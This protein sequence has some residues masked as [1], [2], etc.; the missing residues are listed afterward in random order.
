VRILVIA[1]EQLPVPAIIGGSVETCIDQVFRRLA[2]RGHRV[3]VISR[4]HSRLPQTEI[5]SG[6]RIR[7]IRISANN[8]ESYIRRAVRAIHAQIYDV[9]QVE[10]R[11][12]FIQSVRKQFP[13]TPLVLSLHSLTFMSRLSRNRG[14][15]ILRL[16]N[17]TMTVSRSITSTMKRR[18]PAYKH[19]FFTNHQGVDTRQFHP[20]NSFVRARLRREWSV[21]GTTNIL[22]VGRTVPMKG[23]HTLIKAIA[24]LPKARK[25]LRLI[26]AGASWPGRKNNSSYLRRVILLA[27]RLHV[28]LTFTG[29][30]PPARIQR[31]YQLADIFV[32]P[33]QYRE[34]VPLV[35][36]EAM[37]SGIPVV[38][39]RRGGIPEAIQHEFNGLLVSD[40]NN[41]AAFAHAINRILGNRTLAR[42]LT[43][44]GR[45]RVVKNFSWNATAKRLEKRY[46]SIQR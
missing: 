32:C 46:R 23:L 26:V 19:K 41:P 8:K 29:Y 6:G 43:I 45:K 10:N 2:K 37:A 35:N 40:C 9:I 22:F 27:K 7:H 39:S 12:T 11:P 30:I 21:S 13:K 25:P 5:T 20:H 33:T 3:T 24:R 34:G 28:R 4:A 44:N 36:S 15:H 38:A 42:R 14:N 16:V 18:H 17:S 1:P 31:V